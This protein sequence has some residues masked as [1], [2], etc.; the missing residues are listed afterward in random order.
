MKNGTEKL[1]RRIKSFQRELEKTEFQIVECG[2]GWKLRLGQKFVIFHHIPNRVIAEQVLHQ[3]HG[4]MVHFCEKIERVHH[5]LE[6]R[7]EQMTLHIFGGTDE[8]HIDQEQ[9]ED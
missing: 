9:E 6:E 2:D 5:D 4:L 1:L 8:D 7:V 3:M